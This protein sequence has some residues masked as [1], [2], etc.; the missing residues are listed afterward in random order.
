MRI[1]TGLIFAFFLFFGTFVLL[2]IISQRPRPEGVPVTD[3]STDWIPTVE[4]GLK[5]VSLSPDLAAAIAEASE[6]DRVQKE[7]EPYLHLLEQVNRRSYRFFKNNGFRSLPPAELVTH[8]EAHRAEP[9]EF[10]GKLLY[11][12]EKPLEGGPAMPQVVTDGVLETD[13]VG[14]SGERDCVA[15]SLAGVLPPDLGLGDV[16][17]I[18]GVFFKSH[19]FDVN[20]TGSPSFRTGPLV[21]A[22]KVMKSYWVNE[23]A[24]LDPEILA[25]VSDDM[26][27]AKELEFRPLWHTVAYADHLIKEPPEERPAAIPPLVQGLDLR[28]NP[29][30]Y[31]GRPIRLIGRLEWLQKEALEVNPAGLDSRYRAILRSQDRILVEAI[32]LRK[33]TEIHLGEAIEVTGFFLKNHAFPNKST[34]DHDSFTWSPFIVA[35]GVSLPDFD[36][37]KFGALQTSVLVLAVVLLAVFTFGLLRDRRTTR[38]FMEQQRQLRQRVRRGRDLNQMGRE[39]VKAVH[40]REGT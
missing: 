29:A 36:N 6:E 4:M 19:H 3:E 22:K 31:R 13:I 12:E 38:Q 37:P 21:V 35:T 16:V 2:P 25:E 10:K 32:F 28:K 5:P 17:I 24:A 8:A 27:D 26:L 14:P 9:V 33:P 34:E 1:L 30:D 40:D 18:Q 23:V 39:A 15:F 11:A 20:P 7:P